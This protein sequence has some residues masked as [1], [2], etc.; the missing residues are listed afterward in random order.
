MIA[1]E[2]ERERLEKVQ[3][4]RY[5]QYVATLA[6]LRGRYSA[7]VVCRIQDKLGALGYNWELINLGINL[8]GLSASTYAFFKKPQA[9]TDDG[10][11][12]T[13]V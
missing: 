7:W 9:L 2:A 11:C 6:N 13:R 5:R 10:L 4:A 1:D 3:L 12:L 8:Q